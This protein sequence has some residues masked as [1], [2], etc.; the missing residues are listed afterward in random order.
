MLYKV[1]I[2]EDVYLGTAEEV[3]AFMMRADGAPDGDAKA[4]MQAMAA[5]IG[6]RL[7]VSHI[8]TADETSFLESLGKKGVLSVETQDEPSRQRVSPE[9]ALGEGSV[10]LGPGVEPGDVDY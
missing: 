8:S 4:Y 5:R 10:T 1:R 9:E 3:V 2:G 6:E 7:D